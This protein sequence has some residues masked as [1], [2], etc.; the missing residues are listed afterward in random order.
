MYDKP[1]KLCCSCFCLIICSVFIS[2][3]S[4]RHLHY[5]FVHFLIIHSPHAIAKSRFD[6]LNRSFAQWTLS[7]AFFKIEASIIW[8]VDNH[9][10]IC[11]TLWILTLS[12]NAKTIAC[13]SPIR[14]RTWK[15]S[16]NHCV[17]LLYINK[18]HPCTSWNWLH[19]LNCRLTMILSLWYHLT[20]TY[21]SQ[22][23]F[24][25]IINVT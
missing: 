23:Y 24:I 7:V 9:P 1:D 2:W 14:C 5:W 12:F 21:Y 20:F 3:F 6:C 13:N 10:S 8:L 15:V 17:R 11:W 18:L 19:F 4:P 22:F 16:T 25:F